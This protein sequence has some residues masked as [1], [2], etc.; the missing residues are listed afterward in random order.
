M[1]TPDH[2]D[3]LRLIERLSEVHPSSE[4]TRRAIE[5][6][7]VALLMRPVQKPSYNRRRNMLLRI[8]A[9]VMVVAGI[10]GLITWLVPTGSGQS[11]AFAD[12]Q[13]KMKGTRTVTYKITNRT[14]G[15]PESWF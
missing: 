15:Q 11:I 5:R 2:P 14:T 6:T 3:I 7:H 4:S 9:G 13:Q 12:V 8:A 10:T 1:P